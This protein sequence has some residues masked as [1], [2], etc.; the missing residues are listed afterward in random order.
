VADLLAE[1]VGQA[2]TAAAL[3]VVSDAPKGGLVRS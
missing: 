2:A 3:V 1:L